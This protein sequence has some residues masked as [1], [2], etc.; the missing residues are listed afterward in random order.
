MAFVHFN[1]RYRHFLEAHGLTEAEHFL[2]LDG[3]IVCGHP[4]RHVVRL[5]LGDGGGAVRAY[6]KREHRVPLR[7]RLANAW[8]RMGFVSK[9]CRE[10][11]SLDALRRAGIG[12]PDWIAAGEDD[13]GRAF[14]VT[15][16]LVGATE[17]RSFL[18]D[19]LPATPTER[20]RFAVR[21]GETLAH[22]HDAGFDHADLHSKHVF[23]HADGD[24]I[25]LLDCQ[26]TTWRA[27]LGWPRR[28]QNLAA[29]DATLAEELASS[30]DRLA[31]LKAYLRATLPVRAPRTFLA[32]AVRRIRS[33]TRRLLRRRHIRE[34]R[35]VRPMSGA[36]ELIW[37]DGE[38]LCVTPEFRD[39]CKERLP[40]WLGTVPVN[41]ASVTRH[42][43]DLPDASQGTLTCRRGVDPLRQLWAWL[44][45]ERPTSPELR[46]A[47]TLFRLQ[48]YGVGTPR[49]LAVGQRP[50]PR[51]RMDSFLLTRNIPGAVRLREWLV[52]R[53]RTERWTAERKQRWRAIRETAAVVRAL[54]QAACHLEPV[55]ECPLLV[56]P[57]GGGVHR[58]LLRGA[59]EVRAVRRSRPDLV[60]RDLMALR[61]WLVGAVTRTDQVRFLLDYL[62]LHRL[63]PDA[64]RLARALLLEPRRTSLAA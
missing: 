23:V 48:R 60:Q 13:S 20:R 62:G 50:A 1:P 27:R 63:T 9:S 49:V 42:L 26:R 11:L 28:W 22:L 24:T 51:G 34:V 14:L 38:A 8:V 33:C 10:A 30:R 47:G 40:D 21:L 32:E 57:G 36:Q 61:R 35:Q 45:R 56:G 43:V 53:R 39:A 52:D 37:L 31:F 16:E 18:R 3:V 19:H 59:E 55:A 46:Q 2:A 25:S 41:A 17:L 44:R 64:K 54:H 5:T 6:L 7:D 29:L 15:R 4:D 58:V 12:C